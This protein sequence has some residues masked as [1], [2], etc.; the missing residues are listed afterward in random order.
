MKI[1][2]AIV[3]GMA[4]LLSAP[5]TSARSLKS[6]SILNGKESVEL[7]VRTDGQFSFGLSESVEPEKIVE[8]DGF[9]WYKERVD[10]RR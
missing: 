4:L 9:V 10:G 7:F 5:Y 6:N 3:F 8:E 1:Q 2:T